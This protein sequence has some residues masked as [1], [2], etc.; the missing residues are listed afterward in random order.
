[1]SDDKNQVSDNVAI[2]R[3]KQKTK[4]YLIFILAFVTIAIVGIVIVLFANV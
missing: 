4:R 3:E 2:E 1:M